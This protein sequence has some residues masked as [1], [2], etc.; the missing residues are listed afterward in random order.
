MPLDMLYNAQL[1]FK[2]NALSMADRVWQTK[3]QIK[4]LVEADEIRL[5]LNDILI[6]ILDQVIVETG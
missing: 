3:R 6:G 1:I 2:C 5:L 4:K